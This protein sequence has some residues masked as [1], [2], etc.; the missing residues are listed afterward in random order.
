MALVTD[1]P[2][3]YTMFGPFRGARCLECR[4]RI[5]DHQSYVDELDA[6]LDTLGEAFD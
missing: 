5:S 1:H 2:H 3:V 6:Y 4:E